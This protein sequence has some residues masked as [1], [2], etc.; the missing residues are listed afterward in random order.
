MIG[1]LVALLRRMPA[2]VLNRG[3]YWGGVFLHGLR[4]V[5]SAFLRR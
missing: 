3:G 1:R 2:V 4:R 5:A